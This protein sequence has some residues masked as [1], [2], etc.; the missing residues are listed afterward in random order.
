MNMDKEIEL[1]NKFIKYFNFDHVLPVNLNELSKRQQS[2]FL[3]YTRNLNHLELMVGQLTSDLDA[4]GWK[5]GLNCLQGVFGAT[6]E[7][8]DNYTAT[9]SSTREALALLISDILDEIKLGN[10]QPS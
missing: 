8:F 1:N 5:V 7:C 6:F 10:L 4:Y 2:E 3:K 9:G